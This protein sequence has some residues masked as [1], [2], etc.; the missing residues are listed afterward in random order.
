[1]ETRANG[2]EKD[3]KPVPESKHTCGIVMPISAFDGYSEQHWKDVYSI[4]SDSIESANFAPQLVS[5]ANE[6]GIIQ[7]RI[8]QNLYNNEIVVV[9]VSG[10]NPNVMFELGIRLAFDK[11]TIIIKDER[12]NYTFDTAPI[13]H[14]NYPSDLRYQTI[15]SFKEKLKSRIIATQKK[16]LEDKTYSTFL[17]HFGQ[18]KVAKLE[19]KEI[20]QSDYILKGIEDLKN[21]IN[22][23][24]KSTTEIPAKY[25][26]FKS[27]EEQERYLKK[28]ALE[29]MK[30]NNITDESA[31]CPPGEIYTKFER[32]LVTTDRENFPKIF[33]NLNQVAETASNTF[34]PF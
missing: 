18:F 21:E 17:K 24:K 19:E 29:Y 30:K 23:L 34:P 33:H 28:K 1:M 32:W 12:T 6:I 13:E 14:L 3:I 26:S 7:A 8:I 11:P 9:D 16:F 20:S 4:I 27:T 31:F 5:D 15:I 22:T 10:K 2:S 25:N